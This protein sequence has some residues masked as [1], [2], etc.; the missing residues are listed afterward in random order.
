MVEVLTE[1][2]DVEGFRHLNYKGNVVEGLV[3]RVVGPNALNELLICIAAR[4]DEET[5][6]TRAGFRYAYPQEV[7]ALRAY[8][9]GARA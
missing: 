6:T 9:M 3:G 7:A 2:A 5:D 4:Y 1:D 8:S